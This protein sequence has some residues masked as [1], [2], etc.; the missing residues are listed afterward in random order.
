MTRPLSRPFDCLYAHGFAR[1]S[2]CVPRLKVASPAFNVERTVA[3]ARDACADGASVVLFPELGLS[4]YSNEDL[5]HQD[6]LLDATEA[7]LARLLEQNVKLPAALIVGLPLR[8]EGRLFN[9][10]A[11]VHRGRVLGLVPKS[12]LPNYR[13]FYERRQFTP[14]SAATFRDVRLLGQDVPFGTDLIFE[15]EDVPGLSLF[16]EICEDVWVPI[17]PST[18]G[19]L[20]GATVLANLS[21]SNITVGK[22]AYR[23]SLCADQSGRCIA[24][25]LYSAAGQG[26]STTDLAWDGHAMIYENA[27]LLAESK[28]FA[29]TEQRIAA[30]VDLDR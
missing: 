2:V 9:C 25:Y 13:E 18:Y 21:A 28:R 6:A 10:A 11:I 14:G 20:A 15:A 5:F 24:A 19:A 16:V 17:P 29:E 23:R 12:F 30:D 7:A 1:V 26:E 27:N 4:A 22:A 8:F 3:M